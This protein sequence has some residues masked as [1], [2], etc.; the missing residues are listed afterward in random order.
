MFWYRRV[1]VKGFSME[2]EFLSGDRIRVNPLA[3]LWK[4]PARR[5]VVVFPAPG[6]GERFDIKRIIGLPG[7][8]VRWTATE[9][10]VDSGKPAPGMTG[11]VRS[12]FLA[13]NEYFVLGDNWLNSSDSRTYGP[14]RGK[15]IIGK[16]LP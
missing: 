4:R 13:K 5:D 1:L 16:A 14:V 9:I 3:Y 10:S 6:Q 8:T 12:Q 7:E 15:T 2:P 11:E